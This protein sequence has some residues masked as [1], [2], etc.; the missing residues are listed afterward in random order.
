MRTYN[1]TKHHRIPSLPTKL[2][3]L[4]GKVWWRTGRQRDGEH[5]F[6]A[7]IIEGSAID[8]EFA[9]ETLESSN[10]SVTGAVGFKMSSLTA[11]VGPKPA[12]A[13]YDIF[14]ARESE[15]KIWVIPEV[16]ASMTG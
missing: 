2:R 11:P 3:A 8:Y 4:L 5:V 13:G 14:V 9:S 1:S 15:W 6:L 10:S 7:G 16:W 12:C